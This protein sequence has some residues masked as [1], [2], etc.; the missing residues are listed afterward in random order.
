[1]DNHGAIVVLLERTMSVPPTSGRMSVLLS[2]EVTRDLRSYIPLRKRT[3]FVV[4]AVE[5]ELHRLRL[6]AVLDASTG[7]WSDEDHPEL[8]DGLAIDHWI[9]EGRAQ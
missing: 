6:L 4:E 9:A 5:R 2:A 1:V 8:A 3:R 7:A